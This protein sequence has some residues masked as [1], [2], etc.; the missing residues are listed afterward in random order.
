MISIDT[1]VSLRRAAIGAFCIAVTWAAAAPGA[2]ADEHEASVQQ[3]DDPL[4]PVNRVTSGFNRFFR[5]AIAD[6]LVSGYK[7]VTPDPVE[8]AISNFA[9]NLTE[10]VTAASSLL[11]GD[12]DN[13]SRAMGRFLVNSTLG[14][15]GVGDTATEL[16]AEQRREDLGQAAGVQGV[17]GGVHIVLPII[18]PTNSRDAAGDILTSIVNPLHVATSAANAGTNYAENKD[19]INALTENSVDPYIAERNAYEQNRQY[20]VDNG[21]V[22]MSE[23]PDF[24]DEEADKPQ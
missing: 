11:Q 7:A 13:A 2:F 18:G 12:D 17:G 8:K 22:R 21:A 9:S 4:E 16:G 20:Q 10:P 6:P 24:E 19:D 15:G 1:G 5:K 23:I 3:A 14:I